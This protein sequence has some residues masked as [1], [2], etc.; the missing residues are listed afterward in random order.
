MSASKQKKVRTEQRSEGLDKKSAAASEKAVKE[1]KFRRNTIIAVVI[2]VLVVAAALVVNSTLLYTSVDAVVIDGTGYSAADVSFYC[3]AIVNSYRYGSYS[4]YYSS[5]VDFNQSLDSQPYMGIFEDYTWADYFYETALDQMIQDTALYND[6]MANGYT[7]SEEEKAE[8]ESYIDSYAAA[9]EA[10]GYKTD[11]YLSLV[12][13]KGVN[14][15]RVRELLTMQTIASSYNSYVYDSFSYTDEELKTY[16]SEHTDEL[17]AFTYQTYTVSTSA[18]AYADLADDEARAEAARADADKLA[19]ASTPEEFAE[20]VSALQTDKDASLEYAD[21][22]ATRSIGLGQNL[23][24]DIQEWMVSAERKAGDTMVYDSTSG[25]VVVMFVSRSDNNYNTVNMRHILIQTEADE[26]GEYTDEARE[27]AKAAIEDLFAQWLEDPT[28]ENFITLASE[29][30]EDSSSAADGGLYENV[31]RDYMVDEINDF[32]FNSNAKAG[33]TAIC[34]GSSSGY[35]G[36]H[37]VY[38]VGENGL[39]CDY[40]AENSLRSDD[41]NAYYEA[42]LDGIEPVEKFASKFIEF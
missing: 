7:L 1:R 4:S 12:F 20:A 31:P 30:S 40:L 6:A 14:A 38:F 36:Y 17:D 13:G 39:Y 3:N 27:E 21:V 29:N 2:I 33:D 10:Q 32:L 5:Y 34:Y 22:K 42:L 28:E 19:E 24:S 41:Y 23:G 25:S 11:K 9:A 26:N 15:D 8:I 35:D 16:Y 18:D 37:L